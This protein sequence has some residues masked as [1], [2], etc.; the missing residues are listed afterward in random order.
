[1][2]NDADEGYEVPTGRVV[3]ESLEWLCSHREP[4]D[5]VVFHFSGHGT[6]IPT[7]ASG[8]GTNYI[9]AIVPHDFDLVVD[10]DLKQYFAMLPEDCQATFITDS[11]HSAWILEYVLCFVRQKTLRYRPGNLPTGS[12]TI[13]YLLL[14]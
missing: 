1:M 9:E 12:G 2:L 8:E 5:V 3:R 6:Q 14:I 13:V 10:S 11:C 4:G 7:A